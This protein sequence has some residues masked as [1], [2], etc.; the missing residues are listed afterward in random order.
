MVNFSSAVQSHV[1]LLLEPA[2][3]KTTGLIAY[4]SQ[5]N[6]LEPT[7]DTEAIKEF[8]SNYFA[9]PASPACLGDAI[10]ALN[11]NFR[12]LTRS[13]RILII[14]TGDFSRQAICGT[15]DLA[16]LPAPVDIVA[17]SDTEDDRLLNLVAASGGG[18]IRRANSRS[19][20]TTI[21]A[22]RTQW[23][24]ASYALRGDWPTDWNSESSFELNV[25]LSSGSVEALPAE[26]HDY[27][28]EPVEPTV[29]PT[30]IPTATVENTAVPA[31]LESVE[32]TQIP[33]NE[34]NSEPASDNNVAF[35]LI[36]GAILFFVGAVVLAI[37]M[38]RV[39]RPT[40][41]ITP[42]VNPSF[43]ETLEETE[44]EAA[45]GATK[46]RERSIV[47]EDEPVT[48][49]APQD[50]SNTDTQSARAKASPQFDDNSN[51]DDILVTQVLTD[52]RFKQM[53]EKSL[54]DEE[55]VGWLRLMTEIEPRDYELTSRGAVVGRSQDC[56][57]QVRGDRSISRQHARLDVRSNG[58]V[59][60]S[61]LSAVNPVLVGGVHV[62][63]RHPLKP[64]DVIH[65]SDR[66]RLIF[67]AKEDEFEDD[68]T[69]F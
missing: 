51:E 48:R 41:T 49:I 14:T 38:S 39:R 46:I 43:Y 37:A 34:T 66:T 56:D 40:P 44:V 54:T 50:D 18:N 60:I 61:R 8:M 35:L 55:V 10:Q 24:R 68:E 4:N 26:I 16:A 57:I 22:V 27:N 11:E 5:L 29:A 31:T 13:W 32:A 23:M 17:I 2:A 42:N 15:Q 9:T 64:N 45:L 47:G 53:V 62:S 33:S 7:D 19:I 52:N 58:Q 36:M 1:Q 59:T 21:G 30:D 12:E 69:A 28:L 20:E 6:I 65:L 3:N 67:I 63:N 25:T